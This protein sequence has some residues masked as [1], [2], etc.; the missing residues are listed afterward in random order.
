MMK[1]MLLELGIIT[2]A[3]A[4]TQYSVFIPKI[5]VENCNCTDVSSFQISPSIAT[6]AIDDDNCYPVSKNENSTHASHVLIIA[7]PHVITDSGMES[8]YEVTLILHTR[9]R[10][11][12]GKFQL[13]K[14][15][16]LMEQVVNMTDLNKSSKAV[17]RVKVSG[18]IDTT[19]VQEG[20]FILAVSII[21]SILI[22]GT[23]L[24]F[25]TI[26][27]GVPIY[28]RWQE[29]HQFEH[30]NLHSDNDHTATLYPAQ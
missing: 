11:F 16:E 8:G 7:P 25:C 21:E 17:Q 5:I 29:H 26:R 12:R 30:R 9:H 22:L 20:Q 10:T 27:F 28:R 13:E 14:G 18:L 15:A 24:V 3:A 23:L 6:S 19:V 4:Y 1:L 2:F